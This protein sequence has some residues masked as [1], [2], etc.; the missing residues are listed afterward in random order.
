MPSGIEALRSQYAQDLS[1]GASIIVEP[2]P[3]PVTITEPAAADAE[4][5]ADSSTAKTDG[6]DGTTGADVKADDT[7]AATETKTGDTP[8]DAAPKSKSSFQ[9]RIDQITRERETEKRRADALEQRVNALESAAKPADVAKQ[10]EVPAGAVG[11]KP[12]EED[13]QTYAEYS[14]ALVDWKARKIVSETLAERDKKDREQKQA[15]QDREQEVAYE[16]KIKAGRTKY[17]DE[18]EEV[19]ATETFTEIRDAI[20]DSDVFP[21]LAMHLVNNPDVLAGLEKTLQERGERAML[22]EIGKIESTIAQNSVAAAVV[23]KTTGKPI[24]RPNKPPNPPDTPVVPR[25][26]DRPLIDFSKGTHSTNDLR[27]ALKAG[28]V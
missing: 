27:K 24:E 12:K 23:D 17:G 5:T 15:E 9:K 4:K 28:L 1:G 14:E 25:G 3:E 10:A 18:F 20:G 19:F 6:T 13:F 21:D 26:G 2:T 8:A 11:D 22:R 16:Q 7:A